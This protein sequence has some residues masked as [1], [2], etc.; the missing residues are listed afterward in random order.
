MGERHLKLTDL[1]EPDRIILGLRAADKAQALNEL[2]K[3]AS[4]HLPVPREAIHTA[5]AAREALGSTGF[6]R[7]F[8][9]PHVRLDGLQ[10]RFGLLVRLAK[11]IAFDAIDRKPVDVVF[12]L[13]MPAEGDV[14]QVAALAAVSR[15][16]REDAVLQAIRMAG[17]P[18]AL[19]EALAG[20]GQ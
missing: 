15:G 7:G 17:S 14:S 16:M 10:S 1:L 6:G 5:L 18:T 19:I 4:V 13:L 2:A 11:P 9:L 12:L 20:A 8:A 3:R